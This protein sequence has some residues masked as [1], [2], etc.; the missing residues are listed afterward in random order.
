MWPSIVWHDTLSSPIGWCFVF[1]FFYLLHWKKMHRL[2]NQIGTWTNRPLNILECESCLFVDV[3]VMAHEKDCDV[4]R[5]GECEG[6]QGVC[7][8]PSG[9]RL[10]FFNIARYGRTAICRL[11]MPTCLAFLQ[12]SLHPLPLSPLPRRVVN[13]CCGFSE[14]W[15]T[16]ERLRLKPTTEYAIRCFLLFFTW[17]CLCHFTVF[18]GSARRHLCEKSCTIDRFT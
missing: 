4:H 15:W 6:K 17:P 14:R 18:I 5:S 3:L 10:L 13:A 8:L 2:A 1:L 12:R 16:S 7:G 9:R 11:G